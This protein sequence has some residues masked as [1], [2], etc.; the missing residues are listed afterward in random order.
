LLVRFVIL[1]VV[2]AVLAAAGLI[3]FGTL[4]WGS[5]DFRA[6]GAAVLLYL[7]WSLTEKRPGTDGLDPSRLALYT[8]LLV[9]A[10]DSFLLRLTVWRG[11][12]AIRYAGT[13]LFAAGCALRLAAGPRRSLRLLRAGRILQLV[14][15][16]AG[17][18]SAAGM[19]TGAV[20]GAIAASREV[21]PPV[22]VKE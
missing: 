5:D 6:S 12:F 13:V 15:L 3:D 14:G 2:V 17:L 8:V 20:P 10:V 21:F 16:P 18:G 9:S 7:V 1:A 11:L 22:D 19:V 4:P